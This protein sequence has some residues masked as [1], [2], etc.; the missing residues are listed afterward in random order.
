MDMTVEKI[1]S[2]YP[3]LVREIETG[4]IEKGN[5]EGFE[6]GRAEGYSAGA[7]AERKRILDVRAVKHLGHEELINEAIADGK[8]TPSEVAVKILSAV[9]GDRIEALRGLKAESEK[10]PKVSDASTAAIDLKSQPE[11]FEGEVDKV[12][13]EKKLSRAQAIKSVATEKP[14][15]HEAWLKKL[16]PG[17]E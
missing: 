3:E 8:S 12:M 15:L 4:A 1:R 7:E 2:A 13:Q 6:K 10:T 11:T 14:A 5:T 16:N 9:D 17:M